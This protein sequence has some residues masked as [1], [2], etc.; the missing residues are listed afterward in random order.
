MRHV[1]LEVNTNEL[2]I[3]SSGETVVIGKRLKHSHLVS[4][5]DFKQIL[6]T[7]VQY[8]HLGGFL[9]ERVIHANVI[10]LSISLKKDSNCQALDFK[11]FHIMFTCSNQPVGR[12]YSPCDP[13]TASHQWHFVF[14][15]GL[16]QSRGIA[17]VGSLQMSA[18]GPVT[19]RDLL[20]IP[21]TTKTNKC[22]QYKCASAA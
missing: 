17:A 3:R 10:S 22:S 2:L 13:S 6:F 11:Q 8:L 18:I 20:I 5:T 1:H 9:F 21:F 16:V 14:V 12:C 4:N 15:R 7:T 19:P